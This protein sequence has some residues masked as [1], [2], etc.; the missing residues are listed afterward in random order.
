MARR[1][2]PDT[3]RRRILIAAFQEFRQNGFRTADMNSILAAA[4]VT[5]GALYHHFHSKMGLGYAAIEE[6]LRQW[7]LD[8]WLS[9]IVEAV[10]P[11]D[12]LARLARWGERTVSPEGLALGCPLNTLAQEMSSIDEGYRQRL[13]GIY[14]EWRNGLAESLSRAQKRGDVDPQVDVDAAA[15][16]LVA[17][18][19]GSIGLAKVERD[20]DTLSACRQGLEDYIRTLRP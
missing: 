9:P 16:F 3:T 10:D 15:T 6:I 12:E 2:D 20:P 11:L 13:A 19:E 8:R 5:K 14:Q 18:W 1:R 17:I 4:D 7:I